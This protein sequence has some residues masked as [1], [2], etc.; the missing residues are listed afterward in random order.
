MDMMSW[1]AVIDSDGDLALL[2]ELDIGMGAKQSEVVKIKNI[3]PSNLNSGNLFVAS[4]RAAVGRCSVAN[5]LSVPIFE[6]K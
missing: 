4:R 1:K 2:I 3:H 6:F 5:L